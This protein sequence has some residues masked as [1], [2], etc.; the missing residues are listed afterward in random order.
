MYL[1][2]INEN[3][4]SGDE[5]SSPF[6]L[7]ELM[8]QFYEINLDYIDYL[9]NFA[10]HIFHNKQKNQNNSRKY[11]GIVLF[12]NNFDYFV[13]LSSFK[14]KHKNMA[15]T[16][17]FLKVKEFAVLNLNNMIPVPESERT[18]LDINQVPDL[19]Y[20]NLLRKEYRVIKV[21]EEK[22]LKN[23]QIVYSHKIHNGNETKL[24]KRCNDFLLLEEKSLAFKKK[25]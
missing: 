18:Y 10:P 11:I 14:E 22:I 5:K 7:G 2:L 19:N 13:P 6:F 15:E 20:K 23:S 16:V 1:S 9:A 21:L 12:I 4:N 17:D 24:C 25:E 3:C 8:I